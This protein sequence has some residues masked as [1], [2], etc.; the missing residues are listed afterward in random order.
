MTRIYQVFR[1]AED[2]RLGDLFVDWAEG[3]EKQEASRILN[4]KKKKA[5]LEVVLAN[6]QS[7]PLHPEHRVI[8]E[9][10]A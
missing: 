5:K 4:I 6:G 9:E 8:V 7:L 3:R 10:I 2:L 1:K